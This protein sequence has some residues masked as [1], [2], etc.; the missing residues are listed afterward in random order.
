MNKIKILL[1]GLGAIFGASLCNVSA[2]PP[3]A[4]SERVFA[5]DT[6]A[7]TTKLFAADQ[8]GVEVFGL[9]AIAEREEISYAVRQCAAF[10][11][12]TKHQAK[13]SA[14][15]RTCRRVAL[16]ADYRSKPSTEYEQR[17]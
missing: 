5:C 10:A 6:N 14:F 11:R 17:M 13:S 8:I 2:A 9:K 12:T 15:G 1:L 3:K 16:A 7:L 4:P